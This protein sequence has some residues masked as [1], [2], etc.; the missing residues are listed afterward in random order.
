[1]QAWVRYVTGISIRQMILIADLKQFS[2]SFF[3]DVRYVNH[4]RFV[5]VRERGK[6]SRLDPFFPMHTSLLIL[7]IEY[8]LE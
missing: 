5:L 6:V 7:E 4:Q 8:S 2:F 3:F 1:M